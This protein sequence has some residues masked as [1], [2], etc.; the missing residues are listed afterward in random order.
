MLPEPVAKKTEIVTVDSHPIRTQILAET[1]TLSKTQVLAPLG[2]AL[3][4]LIVNIV[5]GEFISFWSGLAWTA[6]SIIAGLVVYY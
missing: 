1:K 2:T 4:A 3:V 6:M 5:R